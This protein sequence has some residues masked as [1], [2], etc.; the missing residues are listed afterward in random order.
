MLGLAVFVRFRMGAAWDA[1]KP[2]AR[3]GRLIKI[4]L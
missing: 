1:K 3:A 2:A 4:E